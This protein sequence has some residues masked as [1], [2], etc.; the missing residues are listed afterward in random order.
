[1]MS[2]PFPSIAKGPC[3]AG[4]LLA[5]ALPLLLVACTAAT[6][7][8]GEVVLYVSLDESY[9]RPL[10]DRFTRQTG[11]RVL[12]TT[13]SEANKTTGLVQRIISEKARPRGDVY[14]NNEIVQTIHLKR[15]GLLEPF[16]VESA[17]DIPADWKDPDGYWVGFAARARVIIYN[18]KLVTGSPPDSIRS[19]LDPA[20]KG[21]AGLARP[22]NGTTATHSAVL[23]STWGPEK[24][25]QLF[26][27][28]FA[29]S[30]RLCAGNAHVMREVSSGNIPWGFT[31]TDDFH[32]ALLDKKPVDLVFPDGGGDGTLLIPNTVCRIKGGPNPE[33][34]LKLINFILSREVEATLAKGRSAQIPVRSDIPG[35]KGLKGLDGLRPMKVDW[36]RVGESFEA[37][38]GW[39]KDFLAGK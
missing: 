4:L 13:D 20:W 27:G 19:F 2:L 14:W 17:R 33:N 9:S 18:T 15:S 32:V 31:D 29:N 21:K 16:N 7:G 6:D 26:D 30:L 3:I 35:P 22:L 39:L 1:M 38:Q 10:M 28:I 5:V 12:F 24:T 37:S 8:K 23:W 36:A 25:K 34:A 11:I